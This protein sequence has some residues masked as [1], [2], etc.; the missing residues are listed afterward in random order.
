MEIYCVLSGTEISRRIS[1][2]FHLHAKTLL[3]CFTRL[4][5][6]GNNFSNCFRRSKCVVFTYRIDIRKK[7]K[8]KREAVKPLKTVSDCRSKSNTPFS[9]H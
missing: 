1:F 9:L 6:N 2:L 3:L 5:P 4:K 8:K 7:K